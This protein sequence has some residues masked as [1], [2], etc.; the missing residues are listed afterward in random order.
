MIE[1]LEDL[2]RLRSLARNRD[3]PKTDAFTM[4]DYFSYAPS[5]VSRRTKVEE[6]KCYYCGYQPGWDTS[7][8]YSLMKAHLTRQHPMQA[9]GIVI[10]EIL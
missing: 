7:D 9:S 5:S 10:E 4:R 2:V 8:P 1:H 6:L 3:Y